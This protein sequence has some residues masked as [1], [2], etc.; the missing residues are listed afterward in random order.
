MNESSQNKMVGHAPA[1]KQIFH[2]AG[3]GKYLPHAVEAATAAD[4][5]AIWEKERVLVEQPEPAKP[6]TPNP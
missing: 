2:F 5:Q 3:D 6:E 4:A 1:S